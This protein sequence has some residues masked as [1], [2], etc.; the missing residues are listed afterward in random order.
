MSEQDEKRGLGARAIE[1]LDLDV[2]LGRLAQHGAEILRLIDEDEGLKKRTNA[3]GL[4]IANS[5]PKLFEPEYEHQLYAKGIVYRGREDGELELVSLPLV[6]M[7]NHGLREHSDAT[8]KRLE[9]EDAKE[10]RFVF[11]EKLDGTMI[12]LFE[13]GGETYFT[14]RSVIEGSDEKKEEGDYIAL[15]RRVAGALYPALMAKLERGELHGLSFVFELIHPKTK[16]VTHYGADQRLVLLA[17]FDRGDHTYWS[18]ARVRQWA[19]E[20]GV[21]SAAPIVED[22]DVHRG[23][24]RLKAKLALDESVPEGSIVCFEKG[25]RVVHRVKVKTQTYLEQFSMRYRISLR[26][27]TATL[28]RDPSLHRWEDYL[29]HLV[30]NELSEEE[31]EA[32]YRGYFEEFTAWYRGIVARHAAVHDIYA[33]WVARRG[34]APEEAQQNREW[35]KELALHVRANHPEHMG[36]VMLLARKGVFTLEQMMW[37]DPI[38]PGFRHELMEAGVQG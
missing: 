26:S 25:D 11:P 9:E 32:F 13:H 1:T 21:E 2:L 14:T 6:K 10:V 5:G 29:D 30:Q 38:H 4:T 34:G 12:Q 7:F 24:D 19:Q 27:V 31:V 35:F 28:W 16:Q 3:A 18:T 17:V 33:Q 23:I 15:A 36:Q 20:H 22:E 37:Q 8:S